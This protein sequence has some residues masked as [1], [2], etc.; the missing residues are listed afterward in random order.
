MKIYQAADSIALVLSGEDFFD[1]LVRMIDAARETVHVQ[2]YIFVDDNTGR[3]VAEALKR[4]ARRGVQ[5]W[6]IADG[7]GSNELPRSFV[8][9]LRTAGVRFRFFKHIV[10]ILKWQGGRTLHHKVVVV[11]RQSALV[12]GINIADKYRGRPDTPAWLDFA[13]QIEGNVCRHLHD[14]CSDIYRH[15]YWRTRFPAGWRR[16]KTPFLPKTPRDGL[17]RF[18]L[19]DWLRRKTEVY[20]SYVR[21][22]SSARES[23]VIVASYLLPGRTVRARLAAAARRGVAVRMLLTGPSD[24]PLARW[25][26]QYLAYWMLKKGIRVFHWEKSVMHGKTILVDGQWASVGS[27]NL[28]PLSRFRSLELNVDIA[29]PAFTQ[30][31]CAYVDDLLRHR[32]KE[33]TK[34]NLPEFS[35]RRHLFKAWLAYHFSVYL[36]QFLFPRK[37]K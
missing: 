21:A 11:D 36:M 23:L 27:Y 15:Q 32:C 14:L 26:E 25:A 9:D 13:V 3:L 6:V 8:L 24:V 28:N 19:N 5:V 7:Y 4:A 20:Q 37:R 17:I 12:G 30:Y 29:D 33:V 16:K 34:E 2:T 10:S 22:I 35:S 18:R 1:R 31:F